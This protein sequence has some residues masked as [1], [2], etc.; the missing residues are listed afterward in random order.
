MLNSLLW[1]THNVLFVKTS[2]WGQRLLCCPT[3]VYKDSTLLHLV[4]FARILVLPPPLLLLRLF[5][6]S[7]GF[8]M[9]NLSGLASLR[10][11]HCGI[12]LPPHPLMNSRG[13]KDRGDR[14]EDGWK[15]LESAH[16]SRPSLPFQE[17]TPPA[18]SQVGFFPPLFSPLLTSFDGPGFRCLGQLN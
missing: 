17:S 5:L 1:I 11:S 4:L 16:R 2:H 6:L 3:T 14:G 13:S 9:T 10:I 12:Q 15:K 8:L 18:L 7:K